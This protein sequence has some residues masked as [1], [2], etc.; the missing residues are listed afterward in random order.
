MRPDR[1]H[2]DYLNLLTDW[3]T[4]GGIILLAGMVTFAAGLGKTWK[5]TRPTENDF[6]QSTSNR[7][8]FFLGAST[9]LL[10]LAVHS[11]VD[12][13]LHIPANAILGMTLLALLSGNLRFATERYRVTPR[14]PLKML[15]TLALATGMLYLSYQDWR[16]TNECIWLARAERLPDFS[17]ERAA[18]LET[19]FGFEPMN[20]ETAYDLGEI[21]RAQSF[22]G[23]KNYEGLAKAAM[24]WYARGMKLDRYDSYNYLR[25]GMCLDWLDRHDEAGP[26]FNRADALDPNGYY[27]T[28]H[29]GW[30][31]VQIGDYS[32]ARAW[33]ERS[34]RLHWQGNATASS[35]LSIAERKLVES[36]S[37]QSSLP[38]GF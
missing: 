9:G 33:L 21:L 26:C 20:P 8:A 18:A 30:H 36:A 34:L 7:F 35:Y 27:T 24:K 14:L 2:N 23:G 37:G 11:V 31:Y 28:A 22:E 5:R 12:F 6:G 1:V 4:A 19:A 10:A 3:G 15:V 17:T 38:A 13:N 25:L 16:R 32:A 29:V